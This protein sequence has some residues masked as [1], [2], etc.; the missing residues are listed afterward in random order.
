M[1]RASSGC[2]LPRRPGA[3][4]APDGGYERARRDGEVDAFEIATR[5]QK[6]RRA[7][8]VSSVFMSRQARLAAPLTASFAAQPFHVA[9]E[10]GGR[11]GERSGG[12]LAQRR[13]TP[14]RRCAYDRVEQCDDDDR[15]E[16]VGVPEPGD[17][18]KTSRRSRRAEGDGRMASS[19]NAA[20]GARAPRP[21]RA[22]RVRSAYGASATAAA[23]RRAAAPRSPPSETD[24]SEL[25]L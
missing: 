10:C 2:S 9:L 7:A 12:C 11:R 22:P 15:L 8:R 19:V 17:D 13:V 25:S 18:A 14:E 20:L 23:E 21:I 3:C 16:A 5:G 4:G 1:T 6:C 24:M